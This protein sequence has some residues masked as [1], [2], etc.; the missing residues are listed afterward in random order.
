MVSVDGS[1]V[2][3]DGSVVS[4]DGSVVNVD[5]VWSVLMGCG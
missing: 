5:E 4:V 1:V 3:V 2:S